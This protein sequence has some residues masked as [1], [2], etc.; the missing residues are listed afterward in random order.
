MEKLEKLS[1][2]LTQR[3]Q[4]HRLTGTCRNT[5]GGGMVL[6]PQYFG[7]AFLP[8]AEKSDLYL[9]TSGE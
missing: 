3:F 8:E 5:G 4:T 1:I 9:V 2:L 6:E 7:R